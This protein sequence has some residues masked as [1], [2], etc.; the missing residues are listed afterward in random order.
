V[1]R[2][3]A[4]RL[5]RQRQATRGAHVWHTLGHA[6]A[7]AHLVADFELA[8]H[9]DALITEL[10]PFTNCIAVIGQLSCVGPVAIALTRLYMLTG[11][12]DA[13][14]ESV[15]VAMDIA[16]RNNG[17]PTLLRCRVLQWQLIRSDERRAG[18]LDEIAASA[19]AFGMTAL[20]A[21]VRALRDQG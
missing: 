19:A 13:A 15:V 20:A 14:R 4:D 12:D 11:N 3:L 7:I 16:Q 21:E 10:E 6:V 8:E 18:E 5:V 9:A 1:D 17:L 2:V